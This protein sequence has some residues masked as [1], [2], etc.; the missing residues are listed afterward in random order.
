VLLVG[1]GRFGQIASQYLLTEGIDVTAIDTDP[2]MIENA[3]RFGFKV[4]YGDGT[5][6]DVLRA[7][8]ATNARIV[9][10]CVDKVEVADRIV[11]LLRVNFPGVKI[12]ARSYDRRHALRLLSHG[13]DYEI[14]ETFESAL[15]FGRKTLDALGLTAERVEEID[16]FIRQRDRDRLAV[17]QAEDVYGDLDLL[18]PRPVQPEP[19]SRPQHPATA[20]NPEAES[21]IE[22]NKAAE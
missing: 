12:Y 5:R 2:E 20:L 10:V 4:Y 11:E 19:I 22:K 1:F 7:A 21:I 17:Q 14:R 3:G 15:A 9:A 18:R 16:A 6:L 13:V 8:G